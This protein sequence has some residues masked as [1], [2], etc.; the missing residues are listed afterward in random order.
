[1]FQERIWRSQGSREKSEDGELVSVQPSQSQKFFSEV[2]FSSFDFSV[3]TI[4]LWSVIWR[5]TLSWSK[6]IILPWTMNFWPS[7]SLKILLS[8][9]SAFESRSFKNNLVLIFWLNF[10]FCQSMRAKLLTSNVKLSY[11]SA[12]MRSK[13]NW[14]SLNLSMERLFTRISS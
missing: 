14:W 5:L 1:M 10:F 8:N 11:L 7:E 12:Y 4:I 9:F 2:W 3:S 6:A 13:S